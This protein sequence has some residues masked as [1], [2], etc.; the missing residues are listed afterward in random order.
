M[1]RGFG[2]LRYECD[3]IFSVHATGTPLA[4]CLAMSHALAPGSECGTYPAVYS[5]ADPRTQRRQ[6]CR[7]LSMERATGTPLRS[8]PNA[9]VRFVTAQHTTITI[10]DSTRS[11]THRCVPMGSFRSVQGA[12]TLKE[13]TSINGYRA[14][15]QYHYLDIAMSRD[16]CSSVSRAGKITLPILSSLPC[17][18]SSPNTDPRP[19]ALRSSWSIASVSNGFRSSPTFSHRLYPQ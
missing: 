2:A 8:A 3:A 4:T 7:H 5:G 15:L 18:P 12:T 16:F 14:A 9:L 10:K 11:R 13:S 1:A 6:Y 19:W 17:P